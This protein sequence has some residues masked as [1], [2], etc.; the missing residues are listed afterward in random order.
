MSDFD[1]IW[2]LTAGGPGDVS[3][4]MITLYAFQTGFSAFDIGRVAAIAW[5]FVVIGDPGQLAA[6]ALS[7]VPQR[8]RPSGE[9]PA[10]GDRAMNGAGR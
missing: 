9:A 2:M 3:T 5:I 7:P 4:T 10:V 6:A 8:R 1:K